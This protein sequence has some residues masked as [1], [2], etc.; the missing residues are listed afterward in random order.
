MPS[1]TIKSIVSDINNEESDGGGLWLPNIQRLFVWNSDQITKLFDSILRQYP[2]PSMLFWKTKEAVRYR[3]FIEQYHENFDLKGLYQPEPKKIKR[4]VLDGQQRLQSLYI[5]LK[6]SLDEKVLCL[7]LLSGE[8][9]EPEDVKYNFKFIKSDQIVWP[10]MSLR[11]MVYTNNFPDEIM[12]ALIK[13]QNLVLSDEDRHKA[14]RNISLA[15]REI[16]QTEVIVYHQ[17]DGTDEQKAHTFADV[18]EIFIRANSGG[19]TLNKSDLMFTLLTSEWEEADVEMEDFLTEINDNGRFNFNRDF[20]L[21]TAMSVLDQGAK[22]DVDKLRKPEVR[23]AIID[24]WVGIS[25]SIKFVKD[26][27]VE[28]T[29]IRSGKALLS[30]NALIPLV[31]FHYHYKSSWVKITPIKIYLLRSLLA[32]AFSGQ[33]DSL[34]DK[35]NA[36]IKQHKSFDRKAIF[37]I[38]ESAGKSTK[39]TRDALLNWWGYGSGQIHLIFNLWYESNYRPAYKGHLPQV[40]HIFPQSVLKKIKDTNGERFYKG[41]EIDQ[42]ANCMLLSADQNGAADKSDTLPEVW[43]NDKS[44]EF[45]ELHCIPKNKKLWKLDNY[46]AFIEARGEL[47]SSKFADLLI[48]EEE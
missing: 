31:Y 23:K 1:K 17:I 35:I 26:Q 48:D 28:K 20:V 44:D 45:L 8:L 25:E 24:N 10:W 32:G 37:K 19:T 33:P 7:D 18:V 38:V 9:V 34:I 39:I 3:K 41:W 16:D 40:D 42:L 43:L 11:S 21:K 30:Y 13:K 14:V 27:V 6:G 36:S 12:S 29:F 46:P 15:K 4:L 5:G 47:I 22:Y 2:L